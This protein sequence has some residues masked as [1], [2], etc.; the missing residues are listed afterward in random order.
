M[1][2]E[3]LVS[4][5]TGGDGAIATAIKRGSA[6]EE[7]VRAAVRTMTALNSTAAEAMVEAGAEAATDVTG[8]GLLGHLKA[9]LEASGVAAAIDGSGVPFLPGVLDLARADV[10]PSGTKRNHAH[11]RASTAWGALT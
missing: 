6:S 8:F 2:E 4:L 7:Q 5:A 10:V 1:P 11:A 9:M 3:V